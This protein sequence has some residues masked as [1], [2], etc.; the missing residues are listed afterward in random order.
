MGAEFALRVARG[1]QKPAVEEL[2]ALDFDG[3]TTNF[4]VGHLITGGT[5]GAS[6]ILAEQ[7]DA[8]ATGTLFLRNVKG[9][10]QNNEALTDEG[11][12]NGDADGVLY[13]PQL[14]P[15]DEAILQLDAADMTKSDVL[16]LLRQIES[17]IQG[18]DW[19][20]RAL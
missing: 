1:G 8:G 7:V 17:Y 10:F 3:Q 18:M 20:S 11:S 19:P 2:R 9:V 4:T 6:G 13:C 16:E 15:D 14:E 5:S 12:G